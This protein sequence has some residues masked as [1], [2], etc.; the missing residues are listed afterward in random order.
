MLLGALQLHSKSKVTRWMDDILVPHPRREAFLDRLKN[1]GI[2]HGKGAAHLDV[3]DRRWI[4]F[5]TT[6]SV[7]C[8][9]VLAN[10]LDTEGV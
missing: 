5:A 7:E 3:G 8:A 2:T 6:L 9:K 1:N 10:E 4:D